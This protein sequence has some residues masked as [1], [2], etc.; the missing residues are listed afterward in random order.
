[1][2]SLYLVTGG[3]GFIG[4]HIASALVERGDRV[5]VLDSLVGGRR[6]N[7]ETLEV[8]APGSG[9]PVE[10]LVG[11]I[12]D[13]RALAAGC[14][15]AAGIFHEAAQVSVPASIE[16]PAGSYEVNVT[17]MLRL[18]EAARAAGVG[19]VVFAASSAAYGNSEVS[20]KHEGMLPEPLSPYASGKLAGEHLLRVWGEVHGIKTV[21]LRYFNVFGPR[22]S[23]DS[24]YSGVITLFTNALLAGRAPTILG[25][26]LQTRDFVHVAN[27]VDANLRA[28]ASDLPPGTVINIGGGES[29]SLLDLYRALAE[30][31]GSE[32]EPR[33]GPPRAGDVRHSLADLSRARECLGY[34]PRIAWR[35]GLAETVAWYRAKARA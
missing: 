3:A 31:I 27:V 22:Q 28:M 19:R 4:S 7:L 1:M 11:D 34:E 16:D 8:G 15:G 29:I 33:F 9:A 12:R 13:E 35:A 6:E 10:L 5:R 14:E 20:P 32:L 30:L 25:D 23:D 18:L 26:G 21:A 24:P 17:A 2:S